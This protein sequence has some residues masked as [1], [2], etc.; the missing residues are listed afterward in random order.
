MAPDGFSPPDSLP[1]SP[2]FPGQ[3]GNTGIPAYV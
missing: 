1:L 2:V 3:A